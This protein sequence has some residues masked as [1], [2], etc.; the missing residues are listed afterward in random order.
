MEVDRTRSLIV[1]PPVVA[2]EHGAPTTGDRVSLV[3]LSAHKGV[4]TWRDVAYALPQL[5]FL[6][7]TGAHGLQVKRPL[8]PNMRVIRQT[9]DMRGDVWAQTR[10]LMV[11]SLL[12]LHGGLHHQTCLLDHQI[13]R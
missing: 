6:G 4:Y 3:N 7:V 13:R 10:V 8:L 11:L 5:P 12:V 9:S 2:E 1:H